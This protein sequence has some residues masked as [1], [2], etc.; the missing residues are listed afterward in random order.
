MGAVIK[1]RITGGIKDPSAAVNPFIGWSYSDGM[2]NYVQIVFNWVGVRDEPF[3]AE[4]F[5]DD[6]NAEL[7]RV[8]ELDLVPSGEWSVTSDDYYLYIESLKPGRVIFPYMIYNTVVH[9]AVIYPGGLETNVIDFTQALPSNALL[10]AFNDNVLRF[11]VEDKTKLN[12]T[13]NGE[14]PVTLYPSP[15]GEY[16]LNLKDFATTLINQ[17]KFEDEILPDIE[18]SGY[19]YADPSLF[20]NMEVVMSEGIVSSKGTYYFLKSVAQIANYTER[21]INKNFALLSKVTYYPGYP[22]DL[23]VFSSQAKQVIIRNRTTNLSVAMDFNQYMNR[24]FFSQGSADFTIDDILPLQTGINRIELDFGTT[25]K[26]EVVVNKKESKCAPYF[27]FYRNGGGFGYIRFES[28]VAVRNRAQEGESV[29]MDFNGIQ[30]TL[31]RS[32]T[33]KQTRV[34][35]ELQTEA[36]EPYEME[37]FQDFISSPRVEMYVGDLY[38]KQ[39]AKSWVGVEVSSN[40]LNTRK[41]K[42]VKL[43][44]KAIVEFD[45]YNLHL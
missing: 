18:T 13:A 9:T 5:V 35:M 39:T 2:E 23:P 44:E 17:N 32:I 27:K 37:N 10:N 8:I 1:L 41:L 14:L 38:Q 43:K 15:L 31:R 6:F 36:L 29:R 19:V 16:Y 11:T 4:K 40:S 21:F 24:L 33:E 12:V 20:L 30:N 22:F 28:E 26:F 3:E 34:S 42:M 25:D 7:K 45:L